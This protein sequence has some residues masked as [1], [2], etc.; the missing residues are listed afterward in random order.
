MKQITP[1]NYILTKVIYK[2]NKYNTIYQYIYNTIT[3]QLKICRQLQLAYKNA[4]NF[5]FPFC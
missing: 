1:Y 2:F 3:C 4:L 5:S